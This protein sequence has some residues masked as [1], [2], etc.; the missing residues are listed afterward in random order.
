MEVGVSL[1]FFEGCDLDDL[2]RQTFKSFLD[3]FV[4]QRFDP[5]F[6]GDFDL[7]IGVDFRLVRISKLQISLKECY[8][9]EYWLELMQRAG[10]TEASG[11]HSPDAAY[12]RYN[13]AH[14]HFIRQHSEKE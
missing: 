11:C 14:A 4:G 9:T 1:S 7:L 10:L 8:E 2:R 6:F 12:M 13:S 5:L 3:F